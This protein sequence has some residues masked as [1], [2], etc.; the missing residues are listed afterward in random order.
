M[1]SGLG[2]NTPLGPTQQ[3][4]IQTQSLLLPVENRAPNNYRECLFYICS[5]IVVSWQYGSVRVSMLFSLT[6]T[7]LGRRE[8]GI[9]IVIVFSWEYHYRRYFL[10][11]VSL[12]AILLEPISVSII[13]IL[14]RSIVNNPV[15]YANYI[16]GLNGH[17][18]I[19]FVIYI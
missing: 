17:K 5:Q 12:S 11:K 1:S 6:V 19:S 7:G 14:L 8:L 3:K 9:G 4:N 16:N 2:A 18:I 15:G 13:A 10:S